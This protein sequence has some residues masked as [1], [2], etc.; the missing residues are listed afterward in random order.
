MLF[1]EWWLSFSISDW[2]QREMQQKGSFGGDTWKTLKQKIKEF[3]LY[4][5]KNVKVIKWVL[6]YFKDGK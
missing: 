5:T 6:V 3:G 2:Q 4:P 1:S